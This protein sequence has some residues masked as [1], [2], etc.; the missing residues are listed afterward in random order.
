MTQL[1]LQY[2]VYIQIIVDP[3]LLLFRSPTKHLVLT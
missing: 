3:P 2:T 1:L